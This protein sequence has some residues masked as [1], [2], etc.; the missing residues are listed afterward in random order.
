[1]RI[2]TYQFAGEQMVIHRTNYSEKKTQAETMNII[3][4]IMILFI[5]ELFFF[6]SMSTIAGTLKQHNS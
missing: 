6:I 4:M 3:I 2:T 5:R 1:M